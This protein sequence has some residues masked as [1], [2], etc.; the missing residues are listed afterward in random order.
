VLVQ[1][2][3]FLE[4]QYQHGRRPLLI[5]DE[6][7][8]MGEEALE[9]LR[10]LTNLLAGNHQLLQVFLVGQEQLRDT[11]N[12]PSLEQL[13][14]RLIAATLL[15]PLDTDD[16]KA[17]IKHRLRRANWTGDPLLSTQAYAMIQRY[18]QGIPRR[19]NQICSRLFLHGS[20]EKKHRLGLADL[21]IVVDELQQELLLPVDHA[22]IDEAVSWPVEPYEE[23]YEEEK[24]Q[25][26]PPAPE[27]APPVT[28]TPPETERIEQKP[29]ARAVDTP[30]HRP[31]REPVAAAGPEPRVSNNYAAIRQEIRRWQPK[32]LALLAT[33]GRYVAKAAAFLSDRIRLLRDR[34]INKG[35]LAVWSGAGA[36]LVLMAVL[37]VA[38]FRDGDID[39]PVADHKAMALN[40]AVTQQLVPPASEDSTMPSVQ[41]RPESPAP[42]QQ[43]STGIQNSAGEAGGNTWRG[44]EIFAAL[45]PDSVESAASASRL[46]RVEAD[47]APE[48]SEPSRDEAIPVQ[49]VAPVMAP[50][51]GSQTE[52]A[53]APA[54]VKE[55]SAAPVISKQE[56]VA[57]FLDHGRRS[58]TRDRL[59]FP[60][61]NNAYHYFQRA[62][63]LD[64]GNSDALHGIEQVV[65]RYTTLAT[66]ALDKNDKDKAE[67]YIARGF[68]V[69]PDDE[70]LRALRERMNAPAVKLVAEQPPPVVAAPEPEPKGLFKRFKAIFKRQPAEKIDNQA[71]TD[72]P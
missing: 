33:L 29:P 36:V 7:Q 6:A 9:E 63:K 61:N 14:Q 55:V 54:P 66:Q 47:A 22:G 24:P 11:V 30:L 45:E 40:Q 13:N 39:Q 48:Q 60:E 35:G 15:E 12:T 32:L 28:A 21:K 52:K 41:P 27:R 51:Q 71:Q 19:I 23:S 44:K 70:G 18:S 38:N 64:P 8:D 37:L 31:A 1:V 68:R 2:K 58:L 3:R 49:E 59:L 62:L 67:R 72:E 53:A 20:V 57:E 4:Q 26:S 50:P 25:A 34:L 10:L 17:Y 42:A 56:K 65:A 46:D 69:S 43:A 5:V 16:T